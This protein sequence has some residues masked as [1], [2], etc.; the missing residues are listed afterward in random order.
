M[1][2]LMPS[3]KQCTRREVIIR[4]GTSESKASEEGEPVGLEMLVSGV[5]TYLMH[6]KEENGLDWKCKAG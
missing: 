3:A 4:S 2:N 1:S 6:G 5:I